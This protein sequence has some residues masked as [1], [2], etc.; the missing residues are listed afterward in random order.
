MTIDDVVKKINAA[1][2]VEALEVAK[3]AIPDLSDADKEMAGGD[4]ESMAVL[5]YESAR[6]I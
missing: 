4:L 5:I 1:P 3:T 6:E 2:E